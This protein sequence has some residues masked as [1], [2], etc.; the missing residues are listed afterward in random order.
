MKLIGSLLM[1][2]FMAVGCASVDRP[3][4]SAKETLWVVTADHRLMA[5]RAAQPRQPLNTK[6]LLGLMPGDVVVGIDYRVARGVLFALTRSGRLYTVNTVTGQMTLVG[7]SAMGKVLE[8]ASVGMDFNPAVDRIRVVTDA[9]HNL[10]LHPDTGAIVSRD[11]ALAYADTDPHAG[12]SAR[13]A[14]A[15]YTYNQNNDT[16]TTN[17]VI[18]AALGTLAI[19]GSLEGAQPV[20]SPNTGQLFTVGALG[21]GPLDEVSFDIADINNAAYM[22]ATHAGSTQPVLYRLDL[23]SGQ[24]RRFGPLSLSDSVRGMAIEP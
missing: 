5:V 10:R 18:D 1:V 20:V 17:Y 9:A 24:A 21:T 19:Q 4:L 16:L 12:K 23:R 15:G 8:G 7:Q 11:P 14:A 2:A 3:D 6:P 22:V 13:V